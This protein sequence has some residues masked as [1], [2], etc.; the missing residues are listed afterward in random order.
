MLSFK[1]KTSAV[2]ELSSARMSFR[3]KPR[4]KDT[5]S[6][7]AALAG[8]DDSTFTMSAAYQAALTTIEAHERTR[9]QPVDHV[10]FF[11][12]LDNP[13]APT[14]ALRAAAKKHSKR[15]SFR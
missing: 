10:A 8:V 5:I 9:L 2:D 3:T 1:D 12:A 15:V 14:K 13:P 4:I 6:Q 7:A 11:E